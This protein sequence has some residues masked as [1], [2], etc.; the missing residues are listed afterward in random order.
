MKK[1]LLTL[2]IATAAVIFSLIGA[3]K[4]A[5]CAT[6]FTFTC[7]N[8]SGCGGTSCVCMK[9]GMDLAGECYDA[10]FKQSME[11]DGFSE[12]R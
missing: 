2:T 6:C 5:Y 4:K 9:R 7:Y 1:T 10:G 11:E 3:E 12:L 8:T